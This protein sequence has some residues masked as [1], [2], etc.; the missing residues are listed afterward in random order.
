MLLTMV[1][2]VGGFSMTVKCPY[3]QLS[4]PDRQKGERVGGRRVKPRV[5]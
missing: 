3:V 4:S 2:S 1:F 5:L